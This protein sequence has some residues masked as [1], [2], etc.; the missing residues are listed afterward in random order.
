MLTWCPNC[1]ASLPPGPTVE[2]CPQCGLMVDGP[3][4]EELARLEYQLAELLERRASL[5]ASLMPPSVPPPHTP[6]PPA[7][8]WNPPDTPP[9]SGPSAQQVLLG[10]GALVTLAA[11]SAFVAAVWST[12]GLVGQAIIM[13]ALTVTAF[14]AGLWFSRR[15]LPVA[16]EA[17]TAIGAGLIL[18]DEYAA[19]G[20]NL[21]G[22]KHA[23]GHWYWFLALAAFGLILLGL[24]RRAPALH[25]LL[26]TA[27]VGLTLS[28]WALLHH[29][30]E[31][32]LTAALVL[33]GVAAF[34]GVIALGLWR[35][36][37]GDERP[38]ALLPAGGAALAYVGQLAIAFGT[39]L[40]EH[41]TVERYL[42]WALLLVPAAAIA[43]LARSMMGARPRTFLL[44]VWICAAC[45]IPVSDLSLPWLAALATAVALLSLGLAVR[46]TPVTAAV[47]DAGGLALG[48]LTAVTSVLATSPTTL[49]LQLLDHPASIHHR[50]V[51]AAIA[52]A[53]LAMV[54]AVVAT[55]RRRDPALALP[56]L[57][58]AQ[59]ALAAAVAHLVIDRDARVITVVVL[60]V[61]LLEL[62][63]AI[64]ASR[65]PG[66]WMRSV[67][68]TSLV[69]GLAWGIG[70]GGQAASVGP[71]W[72]AAAAFATGLGV[73]VYAT[74]P[75]R[76]PWVYVGSLIISSG[77]AT[78]AHDAGAHA[79]EIYTLPLAAMLAII[80][81]L[82]WRRNPDAPTLLT[83]GPALGVLLG[84]STL[85][86][87]ASGEAW[88]TAAVIV[89]AAAAVIVGFRND[90]RAP[91]TVGSGSLV[92]IAIARGGPYLAYVPGWI[93]LFGG[94]AL[95]LVVGVRWE[96]AVA[97]GRLT[98]RWYGTLR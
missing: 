31:P 51:V 90:L 55:R 13:L 46:E 66:E 16:A 60:A 62:A 38:W 25:I 80:G 43:A 64:I 81:G 12:V 2:R 4:A 70:A 28:P 6:L 42:C 73:V 95:L 87:L 94:G 24:H 74:A 77:T 65:R 7:P 41:P 79:I 11:A 15:T 86:A 18:I 76:F 32:H 83:T 88:R 85:A 40:G 30:G 26:P 98:A 61:A 35:L 5:V 45:A 54:S 96:R 75:D 22:L 78:L 29:L 67:E 69:A 53:V 14:M 9:G 39:G 50:A 47:L 58:A 48:A 57:L 34:E 72:Y 10:L 92:L 37:T 52:P 71:D 89:V 23:D 68:I 49:R 27:S 82:E 19:R 97:A 91:V 63:G 56:W 21:V 20:H 44:A 8:P 17:F 33:L 59:G 84:P 93:M 3:A 36:T 1:H